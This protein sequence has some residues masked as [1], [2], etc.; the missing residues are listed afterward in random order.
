MKLTHPAPNKKLRINHAAFNPTPEQINSYVT[1]LIAG[2]FTLEAVD[3]LQGCV[4]YNQQVRNFGNRFCKEIERMLNR[5]P[6]VWAA[7]GLHLEALVDYVRQ[8]AQEMATLLPEDMAVLLA[9][10][11]KYKADPERVQDF[12]GVAITDNPTL[13]ADAT[14]AL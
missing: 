6:E 13:V 14:L 3:T 8:V 1:A 9:M 7:K 10:I 5:E 12:L 2:S 4:L 11:A